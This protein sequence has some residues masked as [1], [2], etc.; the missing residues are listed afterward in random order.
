MKELVFGLRMGR[1]EWTEGGGEGGRKRRR[2]IQREG[3]SE[4]GGEMV[5]LH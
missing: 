5:P 2:E 4:G 1:E 3:C